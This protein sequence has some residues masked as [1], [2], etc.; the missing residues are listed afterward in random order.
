MNLTQLLARLADGTI[1]SDEMTQLRGMLIARIQN[2]EQGDNVSDLAARATELAARITEHNGQA[3]AA[4]QARAALEGASITQRAGGTQTQQ[5]GGQ[6]GAGGTGTIV[7]DRTEGA[8]DGAQNRGGGEQ[9]TLGRAF[10]T[11]PAF[12]EGGEELRQGVRSKVSATIE[13]RA[14]FATAN[15]PSNGIR[16]PGLVTNPDQPLSVL[17]LVDRRPISGQ[18]VEWV[19]E[20][21]APA[22]AA[23]V[24]E[25]ATKAESTMSYSLQS[26]VAATIAHFVNITR[27]TLADEVQLQ[28]YIEGRL[29]YGLLKRLNAQVLNGNGTAPNLRGILQTSGLGAYTAATATEAAL[30]SIRKAKTVA[31]LSEYDPDAVVLNP[32]D[33]EAIELST[34]SQGMFRV[35]PNV[36]AGAPA[37]IWGLRVVATTAITG[38]VFGTTG[39]TFLVG[40]FRE[41]ATLWERTQIEMYIT[42]SH[43]SN[44]T[45]NILTLLAELRAALSVWRPKAF[46]KGTFG[47]SRT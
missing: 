39:G 21:T 30:I 24:T 14:L 33:W 31:Q 37:V 1:T 38:T 3:A 32:V 13:T 5:Q 44:F 45:A 27:Q 4:E 42:D 28:G 7:L 2:P 25:G 16:I 15:Y 6:G 41:G 36:Q 19:R 20:D 17:D 40:G 11:S 23:E 18:T 29:T 35:A 43:A 8:E 47:A 10:T 12:R 34:D 9:I 22:G 26:D 46:V